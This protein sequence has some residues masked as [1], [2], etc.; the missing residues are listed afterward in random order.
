[1][2]WFVLDKAQMEK[3]VEKIL[4]F[5]KGDVLLWIY[6]PKRT[7]KIQTD[8]T[9]DKGWD[10][11]LKHGELHWISLVSFNETLSTFACRLKTEAD[12][13][14]QSTPKERPI[15]AYINPEKK[16][17]RLPD[18]FAKQLKKNKKCETFFNSLSFTNRKEYVEW[19]V[20]AKREETRKER[21]TGT[22]ERLGKGWK[23]G[24]ASCRER[25]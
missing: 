12:A 10:S 18:D 6:Y 21:I 7:S 2:H 20:T 8:L 11:L 1:M 5:L 14:R 15:L 3:E 19:I 22:L 13:K 9:R 4:K 24:R 17:V 16:T 23:I 25:V